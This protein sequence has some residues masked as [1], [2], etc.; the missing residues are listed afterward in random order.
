MARRAASPPPFARAGRRRLRA[1]AGRIVLGVMCVG[2][3]AV[4][5]GGE[6]VAGADGGVA[7]PAAEATSAAPAAV[8]EA[9]A[10]AD[11][12]GE[13]CVVEMVVRAARALAD[14]NICFLNSRKD[15]RAENNFTAVIFED[16]LTRFRAA[17][18]E[19]PA[20]HFLDRR[21]RVRGVVGVHGDRPQIVVEDPAQIELV[22]SRDEPTAAD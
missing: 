18:I 19:N 12:V 22:E 15:R 5:R 3:L 4:S 11:H 13:E 20:L 10:A 14:K 17:G 7:P 6:S 2:L 8:I 21:I 16:G 1:G 9:A